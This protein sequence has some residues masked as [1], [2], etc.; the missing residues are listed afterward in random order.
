M[1]AVLLTAFIWYAIFPESFGKNLGRVLRAAD[2][3]RYNRS[4]ERD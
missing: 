1:D 2:L 4:K 3:V